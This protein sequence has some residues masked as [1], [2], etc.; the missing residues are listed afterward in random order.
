MRL[1]NKYRKNIYFKSETK[2]I[3]LEDQKGCVRGLNNSS[4]WN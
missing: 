3:K 1:E 2:D 4:I